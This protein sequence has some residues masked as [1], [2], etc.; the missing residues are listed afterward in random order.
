MFY[1]KDKQGDQ[2]TASSFKDGKRAVTN[3]LLK[4][5]PYISANSNT[6]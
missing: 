5:E 6:L 2:Y 4:R 1:K 3:S